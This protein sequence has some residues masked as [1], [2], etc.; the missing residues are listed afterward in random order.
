VKAAS[1][2]DPPY[3][4]K[5][6]TFISNT[7]GGVPIQQTWSALFMLEKIIQEA[8]IQRIV[9]LGT[10]YGGLTR[11]FLWHCPTMSFD[12]KPK[13]LHYVEMD[14]FSSTAQ[15]FAITFMQYH[16]SLVFCDDGDKPKELRTYAALL[17]RGD[18]IMV[19]DYRRPNGIPEYCEGDL[20]DLEFYRQDEFDALKTYILSLR[21]T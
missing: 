3:R 21:R 5:H 16:K 18:H 1:I 2:P 10:G 19:H 11:F 12:I 7:L 14:C 4:L 17:K 9:E 13:W 8:R 15:H 20:P 6:L